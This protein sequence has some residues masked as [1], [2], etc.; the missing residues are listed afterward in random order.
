M[1]DA[2]IEAPDTED[3]DDPGTRDKSPFPYIGGSS[4]RSLVAETTHNTDAVDAD[5]KDALIASADTEA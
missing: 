1:E 4:A 3:A 5:T 2:D